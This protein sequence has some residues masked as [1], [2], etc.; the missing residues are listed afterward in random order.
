MKIITRGRHEEILIS[1]NT[2]LSW[3][4]IEGADVTI[5]MVAPLDVHYRRE[6]LAD[7]PSKRK[8]QAEGEADGTRLSVFRLQSY[9]EG[10]VID[11]N[12]TVRV[13]AVNLNRVKF[14]ITAPPN[15]SIHKA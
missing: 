1:R 7:D 6:K 2:T 3:D 15:I 9:G 14:L 12:I 5:N 4:K 11:G 8:K 10:I 13:I